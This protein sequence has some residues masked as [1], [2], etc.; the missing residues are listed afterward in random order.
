MLVSALILAEPQIL[1]AQEVHDHPPQDFDAYVRSLEDPARDGWQQ[2]DQVVYS[3]DLKSDDEVADIGAGSGYFTVR[4]AK[5]VGASGRVYAIDVEQKMLDYIDRRAE[6]EKLENIQ[7]V[8]ADPDDP[9]LG[10]SSV[11]VIFVCNTLHHVQ[12]RAQYLRL[13]ARALRPGGRLAIVEFHKRPM[14]VGPRVEMKIDRKT[15]LKETEAAGFRLVKKFVFLKY[16]YFLVFE[17][18]G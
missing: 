13:L 11:D 4:L 15:C 10:S 12:K 9:R 8:L 2:P 6:R 18:E 5:G 3:L 1:P 7:T 16:Q 14:P 17:P